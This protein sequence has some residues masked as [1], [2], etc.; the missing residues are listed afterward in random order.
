[1]TPL[2]K[3][4]FFKKSLNSLYCPLYVLISMCFQGFENEGLGSGGVAQQL[5]APTEER[6]LA[7]SILFS[8]QPPLTLASGIPMPTPGFQGCFT[9]VHKHTGIHIIQI[10]IKPLKQ[11]RV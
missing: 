4:K 3:V 9:H 6:S 8:S 11:I 5:R 2:E 7:P 1:M 10:K